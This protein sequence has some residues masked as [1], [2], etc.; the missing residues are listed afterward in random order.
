MTSPLDS[1]NPH[2]IRVAA[3]RAPLRADVKAA[4][5]RGSRKATREIAV[6]TKS[7]SARSAHRSARP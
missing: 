4:F 2:G 7:P 5:V 1:R 6:L 3:D